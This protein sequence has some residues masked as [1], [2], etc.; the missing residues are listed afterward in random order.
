MKKLLPVLL[1]A[2]MLL[3]LLTG[4]SAAAEERLCVVSEDRALL[5]S[6]NGEVVVP[7]GEYQDICSLIDGERC[8]DRAADWIAG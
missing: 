7:A 1:C 2:A 3:C 6:E 5:L 8:A 4:F